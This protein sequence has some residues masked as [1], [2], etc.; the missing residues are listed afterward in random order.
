MKRKAIRYDPYNDFY[1]LL[2]IASDAD[3]EAVQ[4]AFRQRAKSVHP[5]L[6]QA[7]Q[8]WAN[9]Q[10]RL[11]SE[12][13]AI[14]SD[15]ALRLQYDRQRRRFHPDDQYI[16]DDFWTRS[17][18]TPGETTPPPDFSQGFER[19]KRGF[20]YASP[21]VVYA[22]AFRNL[23]KGPY[24]YL[25]YL[26]G[27]LFMVN[28]VLIALGT[29][30]RFE[31]VR[32]A[33]TATASLE[34]P[35]FVISTPQKT[36]APDP[37]CAN[38]DVTITSPE[39]EAALN[40]DAFDIVGSASPADFGYYTVEIEYLKGGEDSGDTPSTSLWVLRT[41]VTEPVREG[42]LVKGARIANVFEGRYVLRLQV[43]LR[44][45]SALPPCEVIIR[46]KR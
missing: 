4:R 17:H 10:F 35:V 9:E 19:W 27:A 29:F 20:N 2:G 3:T 21:R 31:T 7:R 24:R 23:M 45:G 8:E 39:P 18:A 46:R 42:I 14:L 26:M 36:P 15:R 43:I 34:A 13:H 1:L 44:D 16:S 30:G 40:F 32:A 41:P 28:V 12:A 38:P 33:P 37:S 5:D 6:N 25:V 22:A 11:I